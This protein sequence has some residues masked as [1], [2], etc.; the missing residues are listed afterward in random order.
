MII[1]TATPTNILAFLH[2]TLP[3]L[4]SAG[5]IFKSVP[6]SDALKSK[7]IVVANLDLR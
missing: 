1:I 3:Q 7:P 5:H 2:P 4:N 6:I